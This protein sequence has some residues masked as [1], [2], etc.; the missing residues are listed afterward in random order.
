MWTGIAPEYDFELVPGLRKI[1]DSSRSGIFA[2][3][4]LGNDFFRFKI[5]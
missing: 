2:T 4:E 5:E 3:G 1:G